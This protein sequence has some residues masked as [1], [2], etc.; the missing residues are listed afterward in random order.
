[1][2]EPDEQLELFPSPD[3]FPLLDEADPEEVQ[4]ELP[5]D[6]FDAAAV[7]DEQGCGEAHE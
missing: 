3:E 6:S 7:T 1:M 2:G 5:E 4:E